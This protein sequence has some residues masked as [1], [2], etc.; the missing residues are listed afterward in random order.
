MDPGSKNS[1]TDD[2]DPECANERVGMDEFRCK[3]SEVGIGEPKC[4]KHLKNEDD[5]NRISSEPNALHNAY[6]V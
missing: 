1:F 2:I 4:E 3:K 6:K 5:S